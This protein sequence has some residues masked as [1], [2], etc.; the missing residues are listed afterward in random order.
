M[1]ELLRHA[2]NFSSIEPHILKGL[3]DASFDEYRKYEAS[4][5][6]H[7]FL[8]QADTFLVDRFLQTIMWMG[9]S[10]PFIQ[11]LS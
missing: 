6:C 4:H 5:A 11:T 8:K 3:A 10:R 9:G 7:G 2:T 1:H